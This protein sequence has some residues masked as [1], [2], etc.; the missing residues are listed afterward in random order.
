MA[1]FDLPIRVKNGTIYKM[2][3]RGCLQ[4]DRR[5]MD[6]LLLSLENS[7]VGDDAGFPAAPDGDAEWQLQ[8][9]ISRG[10]TAQL[11]SEFTNAMPGGFFIYHADGDE[12]IIYINDA[13]LRIYGCASREEFR[14]LTGNSF[15]GMVHPDDLERVQKSIQQQIA[16]GDDDMDYAEYR[17]VRKDGE[18]RWL[19]DYG[20][21]VHSREVGDVFYVFVSDATQKKRRQ[22][23]EK[24]AQELFLRNQLE[25]Y[26]QEL[27]VINQEH[28]QRLEMIEGLSIDYESIFYVNLELDRMRAYRVSERF[29]KQFP[30]DRPT[31]RFTG[32]DADYIENWVYPDDR[33]IV[34]GISDPAFIRKKLS[35]DK[36]YYVNYRIFRNGKPAYIQLRIV[37]VGREGR[38]SQVVMGYRNI[39]DEILQELRQKQM[40]ADALDEAKT[41]N[42]A[43]NLFLSNMSHD[44]RT[45]M[46]AIV[47][48][49]SLIRKNVED[50]DKISGYLDRISTASDQLLQLLNDVLELS[51]I[52]SGKIHLEEKECDLMEVVHQAKAAKIQL[53]E[54]K[55]LGFCVD[56]SGVKHHVVYTEPKRLN[57]ILSYVIDNAVKY[58]ENGG[59]VSIVITEEQG[60]REHHSMYRFVIEDTGIGMHREFIKEIFEP[61]SR[62]KNTTMS[63]I[64]GTGLGLTITKSLVDIMGGT[65]EVAS[66]VGQGSRFTITFPFRILERQKADRHETGNNR[67]VSYGM[68]AG[69]ILIVD[70]NEI[71]L[72]IECEVLREGGFEVDTAIDGS[73]AVEKVGQSAPGYYDLILMDIQMPIMDG[74]SATKAIRR[75]ENPQRA[76]IPIIAVTANTFEEDR[77]MSLESG[78][79]AHLPKPVDAVG[80]F[81]MICKFIHCAKDGEC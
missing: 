4:M 50:R 36:T 80:L 59:R 28:L 56:V 41:A 23:E 11:L 20:Y 60:T 26:D 61:F 6:Y 14:E 32:F 69:R 55:N 29:R 74:Y 42:K 1:S 71:N 9:G 81:N 44:I 78:M 51:N 64:H 10:R 49:T 38:V 13:M 30:A 3:D 7:R 27:K 70:D 68:G 19:E 48:F 46:N 25:E 67:L 79:N 63:G 2:D 62:E 12:E 5:I 22:M 45:P 72:E 40:L 47:G 33:E 66:E 16:D 37:N 21:F 34:A 35:K 57:M 77:K 24:Q 18:V 52:E 75:M 73:I 65:I 31:C 15:R 8:A 58:T 54:A 43:K 76:N 17:I 53:V 39:D